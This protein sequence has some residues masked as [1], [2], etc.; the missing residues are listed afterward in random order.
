MTFLTGK[1]ILQNFLIY[2]NGTVSLRSKSN[3]TIRRLRPNKTSN[4]NQTNS[5][6]LSLY[7]LL[8]VVAD[9]IVMYIFLVNLF[10]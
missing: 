3:K 7:S 10:I 4:S 2:L 6:F 5:I 1:L 9:A 8:F